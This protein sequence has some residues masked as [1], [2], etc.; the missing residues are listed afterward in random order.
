MKRCATYSRVSTVQ[1]TDGTSLTTQAAECRKYATTHNY[2]IIKE[3]SEDVS[4]TTLARPGLSAIR[5]MV[6]ARPYTEGG[7][8]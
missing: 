1:Q 5:D 6:R 3:V 7:V 8:V 4:G 2:T